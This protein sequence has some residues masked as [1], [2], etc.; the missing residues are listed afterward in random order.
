MECARA[1]I[2]PHR[3]SAVSNHIIQIASIDGCV[4]IYNMDNETLKKV[5]NIEKLE[6]AS[7]DV[8][9]VLFMAN[10]HIKTDKE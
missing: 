9:E 4:Y 10:L 8:R 3:R 7:K 1:M 6:D 5:H 2:P